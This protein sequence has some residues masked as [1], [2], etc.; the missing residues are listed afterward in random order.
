MFIAKTPLLLQKL[1]PNLLW[2]VP[3]RQPKLYLTFDDG[4]TP[5]VTDWV[6][7]ELD[8]YQAKATFFCVG[9]NVA[10]HPDLFAQLTQHGHTVGNHT[11][12]HQNGWNTT[13]EHYWKEV[14]A[15]ATQVE[16]RLFRPPYGRIS[17]SQISMLKPHYRI[18]MWD[19]LAQDYDPA[20]AA[21]QCVANV[22]RHVGNGSIIVF[23]DS[24]KAEERLRYALPKVLAEL[25][26]KGFIFDSLNGDV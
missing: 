15:C 25:S 18:V 14:E 10:A 22:T 11:Y 23:H 5:G 26:E 6:L 8:K 16:S 2:R 24:L 17:L 7:A 13:D 9:K 4:P 1:L 21:N 19:V 20:V 12:N 3:T